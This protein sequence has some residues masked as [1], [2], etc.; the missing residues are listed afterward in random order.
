MDTRYLTDEE[1]AAVR[2]APRDVKK[3]MVEVYT[4]A[5]AEHD[6]A[7]YLTDKEFHTMM[8]RHI[9]EIATGYPQATWTEKMRTK[10]EL[11]THAYHDTKL[12]HDT[13]K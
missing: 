2:N 7:Q 10:L 13:K 11:D 4:K 9:Y 8:S 1:R 5:K 6:A 3:K 12:I